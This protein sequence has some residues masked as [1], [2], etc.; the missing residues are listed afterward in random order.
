MNGQEFIRK[1]RKLARKNGVTFEVASNR[2]KG[3]HQIVY[4]GDKMTT[5]KTSEIS[6]P[7]LKA[8][9]KQL[10]IDPDDL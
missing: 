7:L 6:K 1:T 5:V 8:M 9:C 2:G 10:N 3:G 4:Y